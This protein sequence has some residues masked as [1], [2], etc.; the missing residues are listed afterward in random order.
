MGIYEQLEQAGVFNTSAFV[1]YTEPYFKNLTEVTDTL[2]NIKEDE[3]VYVIGDYDVDGLMCNL[4]L[5]NM[6]EH[7]GIKNRQVFRYRKRTHKLDKFAVIECIQK[8][9]DYCIIADCG[10]NDYDLLKTLTDSGIKVLLFDHHI[11]PYSYEDFKNINVLAI[12]TML[13]DDGY[14]LSAG[15]LC[16]CVAKAT[17]GNEADYMSTYATV[18][19][20]ADCM[21]MRSELNRGIY[22][23][24]REHLNLIPKEL[25]FC[26]GE[27]D[28]FTT[29]YITYKLAP[30]INAAFRAERLDLINKFFLD[31]Q[32]DAVVIQEMETV[33][34]KARA[35]VTTVADIITV[36]ELDNFCYADLS[37]VDSEVEI[38]NNKLWNFTGLIANKISERYSKPALV[39]CEYGNE[40]KASVRDIYSRDY[41][42][43]LSTI[44]NAQG[45]E[46]AFGIT[47][48]SFYL[49]RFLTEF[50][51]L[52]TKLEEMPPENEPVIVEWLAASPD[53]K[54]IEVIANYNEFAGPKMPKVL[55][56]KVRTAAMRETKTKYG[57]KYQWGDY[58]IDSD[59]AKSFGTE[60]L[61]QPIKTYRTKLVVL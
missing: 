17:L 24:A 6:L 33:Y 60:M 50:K 56:K 27:Y 21:S 25:L 15:A 30:R 7:L 11:T 4:V 45:H 3:S 37:S 54:L 57:Y 39:L 26:C 53:M 14:G 23:L 43:P 28:R 32:T 44:C 22:Y 19:L 1:D 2:H 61:V 16:F 47:M 46:A 36:N 29:R 48:S 9:C 52:C 20:L 18:S 38:I 34:D 40:I 8:R 51:D 31:K 13:E 35:M 59:Y 58:R 49:S 10:S 12:N 42:T 55:I 5:D 41:R